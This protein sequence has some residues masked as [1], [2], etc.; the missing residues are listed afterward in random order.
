[1]NVGAVLAM[2]SGVLVA[3]VVA[4]V[5]LGVLAGSDQR[6]RG[7][8][9]TGSS[10]VLTRAFPILAR[11]ARPV[12]LAP[13]GIGTRRAGRGAWRESPGLCPRRCAHVA[14]PGPQADL[15]GR[16]ALGQRKKELLL[17]LRLPRQLRA[18]RGRCHTWAGE[19]R[20][21]QGAFSSATGILPVGASELAA[22]SSR[23]RPRA[24]GHQ[25]MIPLN[26]ARVFVIR[27]AHPVAA[28]RYTASDGRVVTYRA[29]STKAPTATGPAGPTLAQLLAHFAVLRRAQTPADR[30]WPQGSTPS[31]AIRRVPR[32]TRLLATLPG[33]NRVFL[34]ISLVGTADLPVMQVAIVNPRGNVTS[35]SYTP[36]VRYT[37]F[38]AP[39]SQTG[40]APLI[41]IVP[42]AVS[43]VRITFGCGETGSG[44]LCPPLYTGTFPVRNN[45]LT[46]TIP[47]GTACRQGCVAERVDWLGPRGTVMARFDAR[48]PNTRTVP[49][50]GIS[51]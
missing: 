49:F 3:L 51:R 47:Q 38:P 45:L 50:P 26:R 21:D 32:W 4:V 42:D 5:A 29:S 36:S 11:P 24:R 34:T 13:P 30:S 15:P 22:L 37:I 8:P 44:P 14:R 48:E 17:G 35:E 39:L 9:A 19:P 1:M 31:G 2:G 18:A 27:F 20:S 10:V 23:S 6:V 7:L 28:V 43:S 25:L 33:G 40:S 12:D 41:S 46:A 16:N